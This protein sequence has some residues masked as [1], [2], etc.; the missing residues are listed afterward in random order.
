MHGIKKIQSRYIP[1][2]TNTQIDVNRKI[3]A[4]YKEDISK[5]QARYTCKRYTKGRSNQV[6]KP[7]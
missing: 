4:R 1:D 2:T 3:Q 5:I 7:S 6:F